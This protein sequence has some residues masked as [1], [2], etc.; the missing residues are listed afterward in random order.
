MGFEDT[1]GTLFFEFARCVKEVKPK[2]FIGENVKGLFSH[3]NGNTLEWV[4][5]FDSY[6]TEID[7][8]SGTYF[9]WYKE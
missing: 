1:R 3:D 9:I 8:L 5:S 6:P 7:L 2:M 4:Y